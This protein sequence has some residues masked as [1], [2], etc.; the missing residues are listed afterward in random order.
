MRD[1]V[2]RVEGVGRV[3]HN[4][5]SGSLL[6]EYAP[7]R[8]DADA[9]LATLSDAGVRLDDRPRRRDAS[10]AVVGAARD[11]NARVG[12]ATRGAADLHG[13]VSFALGAFALT[14]LVLGPHPRW[15]RWDN[16][17]YWSYTFFRDVHVRDAERGRRR[18]R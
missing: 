7:E 16:L 6:V 5:V 13:V 10:R 18:A 3:A 15:P 8:V 9:I 12:D 11:L 14:S 2:S 1:V 17:L 4:R